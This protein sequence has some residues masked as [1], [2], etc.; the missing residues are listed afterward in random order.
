M[1][2]AEEQEVGW[3]DLKI[4]NHNINQIRMGLSSLT[5]LALE[6]SKL[7]LQGTSVK[8]AERTIKVRIAR[9]II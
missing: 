2:E 6:G 8:V 9:T 7:S 3:I 5:T 1:R 4:G